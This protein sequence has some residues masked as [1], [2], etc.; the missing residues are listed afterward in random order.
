MA[1]ASIRVESEI[2]ELAAWAARLLSPT[3]TFTSDPGTD[4]FTVR[5][6]AA[7]PG[8][9]PAVDPRAPRLL[10]DETRVSVLEY[11]AE[12][13]VVVQDDGEHPP[14]LISAVPGV[15]GV[16]LAV[17]CAESVA[18]RP[19]VRFLKFV[20]AAGV[21]AGGAVFLHGA[22]IARAGRALMIMAPSGGGKSSLSFLAGSRA[23]WDVLSDDLVFLAGAPGR[24]DRS[25]R[26][27]GWPHRLGVSTSALMGHPARAR[28][29]EAA[30]RRHGAPAGSFE[31]ARSL[32]WGN[33]TRKRIYLDLDEFR[34]LTGATMV[35]E[36]VPAA[37]VLPHPEQ[38]RRGWTIER[39]SGQP[40]GW[41]RRFLAN[42][43]ELKF[44]T[45]FLGLIDRSLFPARE[46][47]GGQS[48]DDDPCRELE[49]LPV[50]SVRYGPDANEHMPRFWA[51]V[52]DALGLAEA[53]R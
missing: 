40:A 13:V 52:C 20:L 41:S 23:G 6:V 12:R 3:F 26:V 28:F 30:L 10:L 32:P 7:G 48:S 29:E 22:A 43:G 2:P 37:V 44:M 11:R 50:V 34:G 36:A 5:V 31:G 25:M 46:A 47:D 45:D 53:A 49:R 42:A 16:E 39:V 21:L 38:E 15:A 33:R 27:H 19:V 14:I 9:V 1:G 17:P 24:A 35:A 4:L 18:V 51:E 8:G